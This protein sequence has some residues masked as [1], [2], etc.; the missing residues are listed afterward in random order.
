LRHSFAF[1]L[2]SNCRV[3][4]MLKLLVLI[5]LPFSTLESKSQTFIIHSA[6]VHTHRDS[7]NQATLSFMTEVFVRLC[8]AIELCYRPD[9]RSIVEAN[10][11]VA[12]GEFVHVASI[13]DKY[14]S[15]SAG[16]NCIPQSCCI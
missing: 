12:D 9:R 5:G 7:I 16:T 11:G 1:Q 8:I 4:F 6:T 13:T 2:L 10:L 3:Q 14:L 15:D